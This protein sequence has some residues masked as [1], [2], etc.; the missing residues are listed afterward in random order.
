MARKNASTVTDDEVEVRA[1]EAPASGRDY[2]DS[3]MDA[4]FLDLD[5]QAESPFLR[6]QKRVPVRRGALPRKA[7]DRIKLFLLLLLVVGLIGLVVVTLYRYCATSWR[8]RI[9]SGDNV[10]MLGTRHV[11][12]S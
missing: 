4:R 8:F 12:R 5:D 2:D 7:A 9:E 10:E 11:P 3:P 6:G 1:V